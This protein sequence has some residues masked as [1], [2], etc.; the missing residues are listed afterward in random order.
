L[1]CARKAV[2]RAGAQ[3]EQPPCG[4]RLPWRLAQEGWR[5]VARGTSRTKVLRSSPVQSSRS[6]HSFFGS[7]LAAATVG[8]LPTSGPG[9]APAWGSLPSPGWT[10]ACRSWIYSLPATGPSTP[11]A[12]FVLLQPAL[13]ERPSLTRSYC[14]AALCCCLTL[15]GTGQVGQHCSP[16]ELGGAAPADRALPLPPSR[17]RRHLSDDQSL[18]LGKVRVPPL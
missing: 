1:P 16:A 5:G 6:V 8:G 14:D 17:A 12:F 3:V 13:F 15:M 9:S 11:A 10:C 2:S 4:T 18:L 7:C